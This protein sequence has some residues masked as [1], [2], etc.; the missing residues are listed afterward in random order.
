MSCLS[1]HRKTK[2]CGRKWLHLPLRS[3][4]SFANRWAR[5]FQTVS[6][7]LL[8]SISHSLWLYVMQF[9]SFIWCI[10]HSV[11]ESTDRVWISE[12]KTTFFSLKMCLSLKERSRA[13]VRSVCICARTWDEVKTFR[14]RH[15]IASK[16]AQNEKSNAINPSVRMELELESE[17][18]QNNIRSITNC[19]RRYR[20]IS[21]W[22]CCAFLLFVSLQLWAVTK[23]KAKHASGLWPRE[24]NDFFERKKS[25]VCCNRREWISTVRRETCD[26]QF[27]FNVSSRNY[28]TW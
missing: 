27:D 16:P 1:C 26:F 24:K 15:R 7:V 10:H 2:R 8:G 23:C 19:V 25:M 9:R 12:S 6:K 4:S 5:L 20:F 18:E 21:K 14:F 22:I 11:V 17:I 13:D 3:H 28:C